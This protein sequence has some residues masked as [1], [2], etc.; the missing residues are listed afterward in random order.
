MF[1]VVCEMQMFQPVALYG[2]I[3]QPFLFLD[4]YITHHVSNLVIVIV[5]LTLT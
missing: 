1:R 3:G 5:I 2:T 4:N